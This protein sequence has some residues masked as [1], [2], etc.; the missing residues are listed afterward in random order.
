VKVIVLKVDR[1]KRKISLGLKQ[2]Q[3]SPWEQVTANF[4][5][6]AVVQGKVMRIMDFGAFVQLEPG[7]EGLVHI[8]EVAHQRIRRV[9]DLLQVGQTVP[10]KVLRID[11][12]QRKIAL[13]IKAVQG[14]EEPATEEP[15]EEAS[16][17]KPPRPRTTPLRGGIGDE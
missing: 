9:G 11:P 15:E 4:P 3:A 8:S 10:V 5:I 12:G 2:L 14:K 7:I 16:E 6:G 1:D 13:S 17:A